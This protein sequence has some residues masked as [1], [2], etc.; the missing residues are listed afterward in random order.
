MKAI[1]LT[2]PDIIFFGAKF[3][4]DDQEGAESLN[5]K[6]SGEIEGIT[7]TFVQ[8]NFSKSTKNFI[9]SLEYQL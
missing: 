4:D 5:L 7:L 3:F 6:H 9:R 2:I 8:D 1:P